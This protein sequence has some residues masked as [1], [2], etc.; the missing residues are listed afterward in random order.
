MLIPT[1][2]NAIRPA[3]RV[4]IQYAPWSFG[5]SV[6]YDLFYRH[7]VWRT[8]RATVRTLFTGLMELWMPDL[9]ST[10]IYLTGR[11]E[12]LI[13]RYIQTHLKRGDTFIDVGANIGYYSLLASRIVE[14]SGRVFAIEASPSI[15]SRLVR[16][17]ELNDCPN[18]TTIH[19]AA[20]GVK[21]EVSIFAGPRYNLGH[22]T[23]VDVLAEKEGLKLESKVPSDTLDALVGAQNL[24]SARFIKIDVEGA[25]C[26]VLAPLF[27]SLSEFSPSTEWLLELSA[28]YSAGGQDDVDRIYSAFISHGYKAYAIQNEYDAQF[29]LGPPSEVKLVELTGAPTGGLCDVLMTRQPKISTN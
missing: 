25:E 16:N 24:R 17:I 2:A 1:I 21:G 14:S 12:P 28:D 9:V 23:T 10:T 20:A 15:Y 7:I 11:W 13:T 6:V 26:A 5:K 4:Y 22:S 3:A 27:D 29:I 19:A 18:I 8:H